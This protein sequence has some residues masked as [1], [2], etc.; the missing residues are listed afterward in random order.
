MQT[1]LRCLHTFGKD[2]CEPGCYASK[3]SLKRHFKN[4]DYVCSP[5]HR[6]RTPVRYSDDSRARTDAT[7]IGEASLIKDKDVKTLGYY[8]KLFQWVL[9]ALKGKHD[10]PD[11]MKCFIRYEGGMRYMPLTD[12]HIFVCL[13]S[14]CWKEIFKSH[15]L[16]QCTAPHQRRQDW[17]KA[18]FLARFIHFRP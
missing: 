18:N 1:S 3:E 6:P 16:S 4:N 9:L 15:S 7:V 12:I 17:D 10:T 14:S 2:E 5:V 8:F 13:F 11:L